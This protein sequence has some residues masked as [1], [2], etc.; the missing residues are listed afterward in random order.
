MKRDHAIAYGVLLLLIAAAA[1][2]AFRR[3]GPAL[4]AGTPVEP[5]M[6]LKCSN[7]ACGEMVRGSPDELMA[8]G[9]MTA[10]T[11]REG[12][13]ARERCPKCRKETM[14]FVHWCP[15]CGHTWPLGPDDQPDVATCP[16]CRGQVR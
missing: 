4:P 16:Q 14:A 15:R 1:F 7:T 3:T 10:R 6:C 9:L 2:L 13:R 12:S 11:M 5:E 8:K